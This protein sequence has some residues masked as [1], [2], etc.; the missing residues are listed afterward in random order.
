[1]SGLE[2][3]AYDRDEERYFGLYLGTVVARDPKLKRV[4]VNIPGLLEP[5]SPWAYPLAAG[6]GGSANVGLV[7]T[8]RLTAQVGVFFANGDI[9]RP[10]YMPA[11]W[12][13]PEVPA[14]AKDKEDVIVWSSE[15]F[16]I[17]LDETEGAEKLTIKSRKTAD[18]IEFSPVENSVTIKGTTAVTIEALGILNLDAAVVQIKGRKV[19]PTTDPI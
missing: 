18:L 8:P 17:A 10:F 5:E 19:L 3:D 4:K 12:S 13:E 15:T 7:G 9:E 11:Y 16:V 14:E 2:D 6:A 1:M